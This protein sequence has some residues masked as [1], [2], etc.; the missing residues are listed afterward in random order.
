M[1][2]DYY[3]KVLA[4]EEE[5]VAKLWMA[6]GASEEVQIYINSLLEEAIIEWSDEDEDHR[7]MS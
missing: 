3:K 7:N 5:A 2:R 4:P 6:G 1:S